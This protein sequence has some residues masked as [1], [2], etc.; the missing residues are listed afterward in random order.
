MVISGCV[1]PEPCN[2]TASDTRHK[3]S[4]AWP[5]A[6]KTEIR[7]GGICPTDAITQAE[8]Y[9]FVN[10]LFCSGDIVLTETGT[11]AH[12]GRGFQ[13]PANVRMLTAATWLSIGY[14]LPAT[15]GAALARCE[16][17]EREA[18][19]TDDSGEPC[20]ILFI[21][22]GSLPMSVQELSTM[23]NQNV[24]AIVFT[25]NNDGYTIERAIHGRNQ[26]YNDVA[27]WRHLQALSFFGDDEEHADCREEYFHGEDMGRIGVYLGDSARW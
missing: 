20:A 13:F 27:S 24:N 10:P 18:P 9:R 15:L 8:F 16:T 26:G 14:M 19:R 1:L 11:A 12:G 3:P 7:L 25:I 6:S 4:C 21:G 23:I 22:D 17:R 2:A 5:R